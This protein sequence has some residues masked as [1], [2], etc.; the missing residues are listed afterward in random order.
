MRFGLYASRAYLD[1][2]A[3]LRREGDL[4]N[5]AFIGFEAALDELVQMRWLRRTVRDLRWAVRANT[6]TAQV[7]ACA[8]GLG[9]GLLPTF[10]ATAEPRLIPT[11]PRLACPSREAWIVVHEDVRRNARVE[12]VVAWIA[13][14]ARLT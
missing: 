9:V 11:L 7:V 14:A 1:R 3:C 10:T 12:A 4:A 8:E 6:T 5:H 13:G 2:H